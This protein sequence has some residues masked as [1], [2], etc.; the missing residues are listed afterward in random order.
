MGRADL[1]R[2]PELASKGSAA[3]SGAT[4]LAPSHRLAQ[5]LLAE[6]LAG[7]AAERCLVLGAG[8][9]VDAAS[10]PFACRTA[11]LP[12]A[13]GNDERLDLGDLDCLVVGDALA[14]V[15]D[16]PRTLAALLA[17]LAPGTAT[18][19]LVVLPGTALLP[20]DLADCPRRWLFSRASG[21]RLAGELLAGRAVTV[22]TRGN[23]LAASSELLGLAADQLWPEELA[24]DDPQYPMVVMLEARLAAG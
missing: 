14:G 3:T 5:L 18:R 8:R 9:L 15:D 17:G 20:D 2:M 10:L 4:P 19:L 24:D 6:R 7:V 22:T 23:V 1:G 16:P 21:E 12:S 13:D 11:P